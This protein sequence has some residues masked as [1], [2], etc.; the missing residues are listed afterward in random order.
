[1]WYD[2]RAATVTSHINNFMTAHKVHFFQKYDILFLKNFISVNN[3]EITICIDIICLT[4]MD[5]DK[6]RRGNF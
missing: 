5:I 3:K 1:M 4:L 2:F 6:I